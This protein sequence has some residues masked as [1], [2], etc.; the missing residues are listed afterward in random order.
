MV[1]FD[2]G[3]TGRASE[4]KAML[5]FAGDAYIAGDALLHR[6]GGAVFGCFVHFGKEKK[7]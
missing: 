3:L 6:G 1:I 2:S 7:L 4:D 5:C